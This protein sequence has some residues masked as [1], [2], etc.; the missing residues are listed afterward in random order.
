[1]NYAFASDNTSAIHPQVLES[2]RLSNH[3]YFPS[4]GND[5]ITHHAQE[6]FRHHFGEQAKTFFASSGT[7]A[8]NLGLKH[9]LRPYQG[10]IC[11]DIAHINTFECGSVESHGFKIFPIPH[12]NGKIS[13]SSKHLL[14]KKMELIGVPHYVQPKVL[15]LTQTTD[16]GTVYS[17]KEMK[18]LCDWAHQNHLYIHVDGARFANAAVSLNCTFKEMS[19]DIGIDLLSFGATKNGAMAA[20]AVVF[21]NPELAE[22]FEFT[23]QQ[24]MQLLSKMR[25]LSSQFVSIL[26][27]DLWKENAQHAN[28]MAQQIANTVQKIPSLE[29]AYPCEANAVFVKAH[30]D[31]ISKLQKKYAFFVWDNQNHIVRWMTSF[32]TTQE[33]VDQ[34]I[35]D[36][37]EAI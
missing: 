26:S 35:K 23:Q 6:L 8:N 25:F 34:F 2:I 16:I 36:V 10:I 19:T 9:I 29:L 5:A 28:Q 37:N 4:Y 1:M 21:L 13:F 7:A 17:L 32:Q 18:E 33:Q 15:S 22:E 24:E 20:D 14:D 31:F 12:S 30:P 27:H 3:D 11:S